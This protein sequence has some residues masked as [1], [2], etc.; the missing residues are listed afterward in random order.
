MHRKTFYLSYILLKIH[1][2]ISW[3]PAE[4]SGNCNA[5][6]ILQIDGLGGLLLVVY[7]NSYN[8]LIVDA[9]FISLKTISCFSGYAKRNIY[10]YIS[11]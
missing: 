1:P 2:H 11:M 4:T 5:V 9:H 10:I 6:K 3:I 8:A 7:S